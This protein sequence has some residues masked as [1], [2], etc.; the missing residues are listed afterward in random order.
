MELNIK[1]AAPS[2]SIITDSLSHFQYY[3]QQVRFSLRSEYIV[4][5]PHIAK[6]TQSRFRV[7]PAQSAQ[8]A[9]SGYIPLRNVYYQI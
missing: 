2:Y 1:T 4:N 8:R 3:S 5:T 6:A 9:R 7:R